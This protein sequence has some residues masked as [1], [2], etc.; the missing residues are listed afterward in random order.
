LYEWLHDPILKDSLTEDITDST[1]G[2]I[3]IFGRLE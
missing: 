1:A 2:D 3:R